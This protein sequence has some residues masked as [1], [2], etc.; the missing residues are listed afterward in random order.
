MMLNMNSAPIEGSCKP[1]DGK[2]EVKW[3][4]RSFDDLIKITRKREQL[5]GKLQ[6]RY[7]NAK[8]WVKN[9]VDD[10]LSSL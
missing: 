7:G 8:E 6:E 2:V 3:G 1:L 10:W 4:K 5:E 9:D